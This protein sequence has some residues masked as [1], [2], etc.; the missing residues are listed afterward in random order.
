M[1]TGKAL[2]GKPYAGNPLCNRREFM[3][4]AAT[5]A[6][7]GCATSEAAEAKEA[8]GDGGRAS[9]MP[10]RNRQPYKDVDW[11]TALQI[12][13]TTHVHCLTQKE[14]DIILKRIEF[15]T[16]S[17]Y[18]PSAPWWPLSKM[19]ENYYRVHHDF[20]VVVNGKRTEGP[21]DWNAIV[22]KWIKELPSDIQAEYPFK[23]GKP[24]FK[25]LPEGV[26]EAPNAEHHAFRLANGRHAG[27]LHMNAPGSTFASG[28]FD[29]WEKRRF[30][31]GV[32]GGYIFGSG[33]YWKTAIDRMLAGL[34]FP[35]GGGVTI[36]HPKWS[37]Y[38]RN[39]M[40]EILDY[41]PRVLG[42][43]VI[44]GAASNSERYWD[45]VLTTGR[46]CFGFFVPDHAINR[47]DGSFGVNVLLTPE[48]TVQ[49]CLKAYREGNFYGAK[50][51]LNEL[52]FTRVAFQGMTVEAETDKPA[53]FEVITAM[54]PVKTVANGKSVK[55]TMKE[56]IPAGVK[57]HVFTRVKAYALDGSGEELFSQPYMLA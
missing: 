52:K 4:A 5:A 56:P 53:R 3:A 12:R 33:E 10:P 19:T 45:W 22:G 25:P 9:S 32:R 49:A 31:T 15:L 34:I 11:A 13:G 48:R 55:W 16:L 39:L 40:L 28:T 17:N 44:E 26:L 51:G 36:N 50:R 18:Y 14:L 20:P 42:I 30:Q 57:R 41:D 8:K 46:Q 6:I 24:L 21:F 37:A 43:E 47:K 27:S 35:D 38:D 1:A 23:E 54:G 2:D 7:V 29:Q